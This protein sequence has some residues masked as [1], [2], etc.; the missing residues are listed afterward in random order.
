MS[1]GRLAGV[2]AAAL[3]ACACLPVTTKTPLGSTVGFKPDPALYGVWKS[4]NKGGPGFI[5]LVKGDGGSTTA[6]MVSPGPDGGDWQVFHVETSVLGGRTF[7]SAREVLVNGKAAGDALAGQEFPVLYE[8]KGDT[9]TLNLLDEK[10]TAAAIRAH[11]IAGTI[12]PGNY[13]DVH[14][15]ADAAALDK[16]IQSKDGLALFSET[17][18][19]LKRVD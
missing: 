19:V 5:S 13:G 4:T 15:T 14:V 7:L 8:V 6:I 16:F 12:E 2:F 17:L 3:F 1:I 9:L 18:V 11:A 10:K